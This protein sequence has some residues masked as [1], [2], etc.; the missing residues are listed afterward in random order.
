MTFQEVVAQSEENHKREFQQ[1]KQL[2]QTE[3]SL[4]KEQLCLE[5]QEAPAMTSTTNSTIEA[6]L[7]I[8]MKHL[9]LTVNYPTEKTTDTSSPPRKRR[10]QSATPTSIRRIPDTLTDEDHYP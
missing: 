5:Q 8:I 7:D 2:F 1:L 4:L 6:K 9:Q 10:D 3:L